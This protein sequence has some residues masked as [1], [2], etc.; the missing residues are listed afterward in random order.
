[1]NNT[2]LRPTTGIATV[3]SKGQITIP[4]KLV[5]ALGWRGPM[6]VIVE[7]QDSQIVVT[8]A[9]SAPANRKEPQR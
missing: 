6:Q 3:T 9:G 1:M 8:P 7:E 2:K 4:I 5:R